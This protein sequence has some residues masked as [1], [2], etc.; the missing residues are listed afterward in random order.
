M[1]RAMP[2]FCTPYITKNV[3][4]MLHLS[5]TAKI[6]STRTSHSTYYESQE[7]FFEVVQVFYANDL[8]LGRIQGFVF[9]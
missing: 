4:I 5:P 7:P 1:A 6:F 2:L 3:F 8:E 9:F